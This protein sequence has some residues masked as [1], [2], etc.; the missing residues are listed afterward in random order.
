M[1]TV[2]ITP[3]LKWDEVLQQAKDEDVVLTRQG[4]AVAMLSD[5]DDEDV[6]WY[7]RERHPEFVASISKARLQV[8]AGET[9]SHQDVRKQLGIQ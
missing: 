5:F 8:T 6:Y 2:E 9:T 7:Q 4:H 3:E 1:K